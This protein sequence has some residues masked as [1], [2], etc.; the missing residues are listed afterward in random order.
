MFR[1]LINWVMVALVVPAIAYAQT[2]N[3]ARVTRTSVIVEQPRGDSPVITTVPPG[4]VLELVTEQ[5][6]WYQVALLTEGAAGRPAGWINRALVE[7]LPTN[8]AAS[9]TAPAVPAPQ[10]QATVTQRAP[11][12]PKPPAP[13]TQSFAGLDSAPA[14]TARPLADNVVPTSPGAAPSTVRPAAN[15]SLKGVRRI[16]IET[17]PNNLDQYISAEIAKDLKGRV[18]LVLDKANADA[19]MRGVGEQRT[20]VG[21]AITGRYLGLHDDASGSI[22]LVDPG[23]TVVLWASEAGDRSLMWGAMA[24]GGQRKVADRLV[25]NLKKALSEAK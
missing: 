10:L 11:Q 1:Q 16:Y 15:N 9:P 4:V 13:A 19:I 14:A 24:R 5:G 20:G 21:A 8:R 23:E 7:L 17:M 12:I 2:N 22:S 18:V 3:T 6:E 25:N